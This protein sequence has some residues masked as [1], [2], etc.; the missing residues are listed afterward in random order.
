MALLL[1]I[2]GTCLA[3]T[4]LIALMVILTRCKQT[5]TVSPNIVLLYQIGRG[6]LAPS[7]SPFPLKLETFLRMNK[8]PYM[9]D[10]SAKFSSKGKTPWME[11]NGKAIADSQFCIE[12]LKKEKNI[13]ANCHLTKDQIG[14]AKAFQRLTEENLYWT[15]CLES[16]GGDVSSMKKIIPYK[17]IKLWLTLKFLKRII[18][19]ETWGQGIGRHTPEEVWS[20][21][22]H[23][24]TAISSFLGEKTFFMGEEPCEVDCVL[25]G[26]IAMI[27]YNMPGSKHE[28]L[29]KDVLV[30][31]VSY[32]ERMKNKYWPDWNE[33]IRNSSTF[34]DDNRV[35]YKHGSVNGST[36]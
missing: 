12:Y 25:F 20:I 7:I 6:N 17:G 4:V 36:K 19:Q 13:D 31:L 22:V 11:Y 5:K 1:L 35:V 9:N 24:L 23:D 3:A 2:F 29:I 18:K 8:I 15:M 34:V 27:L 26:M 30:N 14:I 10:H 16:F 33:R 28:K 32:C 21:A